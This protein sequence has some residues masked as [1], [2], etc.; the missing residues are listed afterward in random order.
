MS[1]SPEAASNEPKKWV[2]DFYHQTKALKGAAGG[3]MVVEGGGSVGEEKREE[4]AAWERTRG[5]SYRFREEGGDY[6]QMMYDEHSWPPKGGHPYTCLHDELE[7]TTTKRGFAEVDE[8]LRRSWDADLE[9]LSPD[10]LRKQ[11]RLFKEI[12]L[13]LAE[14]AHRF[15]NHAKHVEAYVGKPVDQEDADALARRSIETFCELPAFT[16][17]ED[18]TTYK[19]WLGDQEGRARADDVKPGDASNH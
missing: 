14:V 9:K 18:E 12:S 10:E 3:G 11:L 16:R 7:K 2:E 5:I 6:S 8:Q 15:Y 1:A 17:P 4:E 19:Q 13:H